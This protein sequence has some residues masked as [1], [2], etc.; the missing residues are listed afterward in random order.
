MSS[1]V[2]PSADRNVP[3]NAM[4]EAAAHRFEVRPQDI[5]RPRPLLTFQPPAPAQYRVP[6]R[7]GMS[8]IIGIITALAILFG[9]FHNYNAHPLLYLFFGVQAIVICLAQMLNGKAPRAASA[10]A[11]AVLLPIFC[12]AAAAYWDPRHRHLNSLC[13]VVG[14]IP[15]G[16]L[17]GYVTGTLAA[18]I[19]LVMDGAERLLSVAPPK[20]CD[21]RPRIV[22]EGGLRRQ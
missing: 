9:G 18:G 19:F 16:A 13:A 11:G 2:P 20:K 5:Y 21:W 12:L 3:L 8:A 17:L 6:R 4:V 1:D 15:I 10:I 14:G 22:D 7:F